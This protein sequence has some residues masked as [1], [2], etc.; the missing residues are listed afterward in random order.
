MSTSTYYKPNSIDFIIT[1][2]YCPHS[3]IVS[4]PS[5]RSVKIS[6]TTYSVF[7]V[8]PIVNDCVIYTDIKFTNKGI[9]FFKICCQIQQGKSTIDCIN[10]IWYWLRCIIGMVSSYYFH[11]ARYFQCYLLEYIFHNTVQ[12]V[13]YVYVEASNL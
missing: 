6:F 10:Y 11:V 1:L 5:L 13:I 4:L 12:L 3:S 9:I 7:S 8:L 2:G